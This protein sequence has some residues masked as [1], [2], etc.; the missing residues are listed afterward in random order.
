MKVLYSI[1]IIACFG[2]CRFAPFAAADEKG[3]ETTK[4]GQIEAKLNR[5]EL[6]TREELD[7]M[8]E[9]VRMTA[10]RAFEAI[11][12]DATAEQRAAI[13]KGIVK[14]K[15]EMMAKLD[16]AEDQL[17][18]HVMLHPVVPPNAS[19][20]ERDWILNRAPK[21][22]KRLLDIV[23]SDLPDGEKEK[24]LRKVNAEALKDYQQLMGAK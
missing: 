10:C 9:H 24:A 8:S 13:F 3:K 15:K 19:P 1:V 2:L 18:E 6:L 23:K 11:P 22:T 7:L 4:I 5:G 16:K 14:A 17:N 20:K 12:Q 21:Y